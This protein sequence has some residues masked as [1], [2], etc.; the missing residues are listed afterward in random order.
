MLGQQAGDIPLSRLES[1]EKNLSGFILVANWT[2]ISIITM[3][4][5]L[6]SL[7]SFEL[8]GWIG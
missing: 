7:I 6:L 5:V 3:A 1:L 8:R 2:F 4:L